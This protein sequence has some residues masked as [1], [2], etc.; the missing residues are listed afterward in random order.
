MSGR[1]GWTGWAAALAL[2]AFAMAGALGAVGL[3]GAEHARIVAEPYA[4]PGSALWL[5]ADALGRDLGARV[6]AGAQVSLFVGVAGALGTVGFGGLLGGLAGLRG[7]ALERALVGLADAVA[8]LPGVVAL[9]GV[10]LCVG[11]GLVGAAA[12]IILTQWTGVFRSVRAESRRLQSA[13]FYRAA[14]A[15]GAG[16][17]HQLRHHLAPHLR[18]LLLTSTALLFVHAIKVEAVIAFFGY[19][20]QEA[21]SWGALLAECGG[22]VARGIWWPAVGASAPLAVVVLAAQVLA[23]RI[24]EA[25]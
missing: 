15:M 22:E 4:P 3:A 18:P 9:L 5:G 1:L 6:L 19:S 12:A 13:D 24:E 10:A 23:D 2:A 25:G 14:E 16:V 17:G 20:S 7:G 21:P 11:P 8:A